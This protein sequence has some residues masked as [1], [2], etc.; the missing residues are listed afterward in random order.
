MQI[1]LGWPYLWVWASLVSHC[2]HTCNSL[3]LFSNSAFVYENV[4][5]YQYGSWT[6]ENSGNGFSWPKQKK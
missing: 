3:D 5:M 1:K 6:R 2:T 4:F